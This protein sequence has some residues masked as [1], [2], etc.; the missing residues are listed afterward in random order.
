MS[1]TCSAIKQL[2]EAFRSS[3]FSYKGVHWLH[4][5]CYIYQH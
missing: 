1:K 3:A 4:R 5:R 2:L